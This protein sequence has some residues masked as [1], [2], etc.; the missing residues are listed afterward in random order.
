VPSDT[1]LS[2]GRCEDDSG[3]DEVEIDGVEEDAKSEALE[4]A[5]Q[6]C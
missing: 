4:S 1:G 3:T 6:C 2:L 5:M